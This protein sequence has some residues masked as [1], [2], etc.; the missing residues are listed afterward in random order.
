[1]DLS[2]RIRG[3]EIVVIGCSAGGFHA[4]QAVL[5]PLPAGFPLPVVVV[6]HLGTDHGPLLSDLLSRTCALLVREAEDKALLEPG[7]V[8]VAAPN[9]HL[10]LEA[11]GSLAL[12]VDPKV[13]GVRPSIDVLFESAAEAFGPGVIGVVLTGANDDGARGLRRIRDAGGIGIVQY[14]ED[15]YAGTMPEAAIAGGGADHVLPLAEIAGLLCRLVKR[16]E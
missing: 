14:P 12:S 10:L 15:A 13:C 9:Y 11:G 4:L 8:Q 1:M 7:V 2:P 16:Q 5:N 3:P 6:S